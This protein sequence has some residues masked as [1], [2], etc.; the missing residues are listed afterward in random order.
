MPIGNA[1]GMSDTLSSPTLPA[2]AFPSGVSAEAAGSWSLTAAERA[3]LPNTA[4][5][6]FYREHGWWISPRIVSDHDLAVAQESADR[7]YAG[8]RDMPWP[9][10]VYPDCGWKPENGPGLRK[11][12]YAT[13]EMRGLSVLMRTPLLGATAALLAEVDS[14]RLWH[15][16]LLYK[17]GDPASARQ[18]HVGWHTDR[19][20]WKVCSS[21][22]MLTAW[23]P[24]H[25]CPEEMGTIT[26]IDGS[27]RWA[28]HSMRLN[29][30]DSDLDK[31]E[32]E[33][34]SGGLPVVKVPMVLAKGQASFHSV[35][36]R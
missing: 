9:G 5:L 15:D 7:Y 18:D 16:Q 32:R 27:H 33:F 28:D 23:I 8:E 25:D 12:D 34:D 3:L 17:P 24:F 22:R 20:Y 4:D 13:L 29:F 26:M 35:N 10:Q 14:V 30:F 11:N 36:V 19:G 21:D 2:T 1:A 31:L 6:A